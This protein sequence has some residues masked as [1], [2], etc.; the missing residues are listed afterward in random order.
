[1]EESKASKEFMAMLRLKFSD[2]ANKE[3]I[4]NLPT[5]LTAKG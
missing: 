3:K 5:P 2:Y 1:M 4:A